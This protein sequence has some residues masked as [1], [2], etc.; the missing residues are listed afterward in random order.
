MKGNKPDEWQFREPGDDNDD[1][2][3]NKDKGKR[4]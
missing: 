2:D 1:M 3:E 4:K